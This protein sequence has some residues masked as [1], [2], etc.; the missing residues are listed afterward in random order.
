MASL[1]HQGCFPQTQATAIPTMWKMVYAVLMTIFLASITSLI[2]A[3]RLTQNMVWCKFWTI[4]ILIANFSQLPKGTT[5]P[6]SYPIPCMRGSF[7]TKRQFSYN[8]NHCNQRAIANDVCCPEDAVPCNAD[9]PNY[10][11]RANPE[12][13]RTLTKV[14]LFTC[15]STLI[16]F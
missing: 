8:E 6:E 10:L 2:T 7:C 1:A 11:C 14:N 5:C 9:D 13:G 15:W 3:A 16:T 12:Y 4:R